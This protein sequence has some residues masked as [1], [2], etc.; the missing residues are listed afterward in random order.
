MAEDNGM[1]NEDRDI[2][3]SDGRH[4]GTFKVM[5][6]VVDAHDHPSVDF[7]RAEKG[8][9]NSMPTCSYGV[10]G[11]LAGFKRSGGEVVGSL[12]R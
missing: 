1:K 6:K 8:P 10:L 7:R 12:N 9:R 5:S 11:G 4:G 3:I 2:G